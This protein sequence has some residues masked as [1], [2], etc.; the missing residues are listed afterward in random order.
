[1]DGEMV[2]VSLEGALL[3]CEQPLVLEERFGLKIRIPDRSPIEM[4]GEVVRSN[5]SGP[6]EKESECKV[7]IRFVDISEEK[8]RQ[9]YRAVR[10]ELKMQTKNSHD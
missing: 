1:M 8:E 4:I 7:G 10:E 2:N 6:E 5:I 3:L 9:L